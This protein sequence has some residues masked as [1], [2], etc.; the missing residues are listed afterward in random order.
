MLNTQ[1]NV[2]ELVEFKRPEGVGRKKT[3]NFIRTCAEEVGV[4]GKYEVSK[5]VD[6]KNRLTMTNLHQD[7]SNCFLLQSSI[8][9]TVCLDQFNA[10]FPE[11]L[12][13]FHEES[14]KRNQRDID[15]FNA[16]Y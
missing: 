5:P 13:P 10:C 1:G 6:F 2:E 9:F 14:Q 3:W 4:G 15:A 12:R 7:K 8:A 16:L 11:R